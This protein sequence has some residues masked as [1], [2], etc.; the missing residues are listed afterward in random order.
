MSVVLTYLPIRAR[1][2]AIKMIL[3]YGN[4]PYEYIEIPVTKW[5]QAKNDTQISHF[6]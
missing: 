4:V 3:E 2:E 1:A 6:G 5:P